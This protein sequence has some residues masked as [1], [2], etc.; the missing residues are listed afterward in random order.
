MTR[1]EEVYIVAGI[2]LA[3]LSCLAAWLAL[4]QVQVLF[5]RSK[6]MTQTQESSLTTPPE[7]QVL[8][9]APVDSIDSSKPIT[10]KN[11]LDVTGEWRGVR[12]TDDGQRWKD[13]WY[14]SQQVVYVQGTVRVEVGGHPEYYVVKQ[15]RG[16]VSNEI[17]SFS[18]VSFLEKQVGP[19]VGWCLSTGRLSFQSGSG[20]HLR[21]LLGPGA[22]PSGCDASIT[23]EVIIERQ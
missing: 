9:F 14:L 2:A 22:G 6:Q 7:S 21:G 11:E 13:R 15:V 8:P 16:S 4:P 3:A 17:F 5:S 10:V 1:K 23:G 20:Q 19:Y 18:E 12:Y